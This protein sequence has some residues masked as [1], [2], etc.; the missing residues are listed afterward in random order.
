MGL[1]KAPMQDVV[2]PGLADGSPY[3]FATFNPWLN[4]LL[5][6]SMTGDRQQLSWVNLNAKKCVITKLLPATIYLC[7]LERPF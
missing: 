4:V 5:S 1:D 7:W 6:E 2:I 3:Y